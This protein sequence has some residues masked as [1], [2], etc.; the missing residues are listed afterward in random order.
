MLGR[1][2]SPHARGALAGPAHFRTYWRD[3]VDG[4]PQRLASNFDVE[5]GV[6]LAGSRAWPLTVSNQ[7]IGN[8]YPCSF[9]T[10]YVE[11]PRAEARQ[12]ASRIESALALGAFAALDLLLRAAGIDRHVQW[13]SWLLSTHLHP[14][15]IC[16]A[17]AP[18]TRLLVDRFPDH[19]IAVRCVD[20]RTDGRLVEALRDE[21]YVLVPARQVWYF[22]G[23]RAEFRERSDVRKDSRLLDGLRDYA[24]CDLDQLAASDLARATELYRSLY[25]ERHTHFNPAYGE[26]FLR[27][28]V[29]GR[30]LRAKV[31]RHRSGRIDGVMARFDGD[32]TASVP[33]IGYDARLPQE[34]GLYRALFA[35]LLR[36]VATEGA[37]LNYSS[38][39]GEFKRRRGGEMSVE[40]NAFYARHLPLVRRETLHG[41]CRAI[42]AAAMRLFAQRVL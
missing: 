11:Y 15:G 12:L 36:D 25:L 27:L 16:E 34:L 19:A 24:Y 4:G 42:N 30:W 39:A 13:S 20:P 10:H 7:A 41:V 1:R 38:G 2:A 21:G 29:P 31:L 28:G 22:D 6:A 26:D 33:F 14:T 40:Y 18:V 5:A 17:V 3:V 32:R 35:A 9:H 23:A 37:L 8:A